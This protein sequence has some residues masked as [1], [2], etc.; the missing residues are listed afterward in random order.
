MQ[1]TS[2]I[3][4]LCAI[5]S[6]IICQLAIA[7]PVDRAATRESR[8]EVVAIK[9][10]APQPQELGRKAGL[11]LGMRG[12]PGTNDPGEV[13]FTGSIKSL[14]IASYSV[15]SYQVSGPSWLDSDLFVAV[16]KVPTGTTRD[17]LPSM[18]LNV[19]A[20][21]FHLKTHQE[22]KKISVYDLV[23]SRNGAKLTV[24][25]PVPK[26]SDRA[27]EGPVQF[28]VGP[29]GCPV[30]ADGRRGPSTKMLPTAFQ[31]CAARMT[32]DTLIHFLNGFVDRPIIDKTDLKDKYD[33]KLEFSP[34]A[35]M[36]PGEAP[37]IPSS[38]NLGPTPAQSL[39]VALQNQLGLRLAPGTGDAKVVVVDS[40]SR[41]PTPN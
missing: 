8:F 27:N 6:L 31:I 21:R 25:P 10:F 36:H 20:D 37:G 34:D 35:T 40:V 39:F 26:S 38:D 7:Q 28:S 17:D 12:G 3:T 32:M 5:A 19:L 15:R 29:D 24:S 16:A 9:P 22:T 1:Q 41:Q 18:W 33:F 23:V 30:L 4:T 13:T 14:I 11:G 2:L